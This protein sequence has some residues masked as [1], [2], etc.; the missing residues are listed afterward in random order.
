MA[1]H[2]V[3]L[4]AFLKGGQWDRVHEER[5]RCPVIMSMD[6]SLSPRRALL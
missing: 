4:L 2:S 3:A 5:F 6:Y 1:L